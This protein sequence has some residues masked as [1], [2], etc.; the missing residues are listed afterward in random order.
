MIWLVGRWTKAGRQLSAVRRAIGSDPSRFA[1]PAVFCG[2]RP[3]RADTLRRL[4]RSGD[5]WFTQ[6]SLPKG[7]RV[8]TVVVGQRGASRDL[9]SRL[10]RDSRAH[11]WASPRFIPQEG[12]VDE[13]LNGRDWWYGCPDRLNQALA[14]HDGLKIAHRLHESGAP[15]AWPST[16]A[17]ET[18]QRAT[19]PGTFATES[20]LHQLG[21]RI[22]GLSRERRWAI[23]T[24]AAVPT[25]GLQQVAET[26]A[27][28]VRARKRQRG[29]RERY[30][31]AITEWEHDLARLKQEYWARAGRRFPWPSSE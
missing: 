23:L 1:T 18:T 8:G 10:L 4:L 28:L 27:G 26:I 11:G 24:H 19:A 31:N 7:T 20:T 2:D 14:W 3:Y 25:L 9:M 6:S 17:L 22:T 30:A 15:I 21:Y 5:L 12:F 29:G 13:I 16:T